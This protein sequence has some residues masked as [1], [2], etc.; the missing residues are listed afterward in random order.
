MDAFA[1]AAESA[2]KWPAGSLGA[3]YFESAEAGVDRLAAPEAAFALV[4]PSFLY[5]YGRKLSLEPVLEA[6]PLAGQGEA[7]ALVAGKGRVTSPASLAGWEITGA[8]GFSPSFV[9]EVLL[10]EWGPLPGDARIT[11][12][13]AI[14]GALRRA[15]TVEKLAVLL[16]RSQADAMPTLPFSTKLEVVRVSRTV[17]AALW[18]AVGKRVPQADSERLTQALLHLQDQ[19]SGK[20]ILTTLRIARFE[21]VNSAALADLRMSPSGTKP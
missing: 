8:P 5:E 11:F 12:S 16:D 2:A 6:K 14:L 17:P 21:K 1:S 3:I 15:A 18:C 20:E 19:Q 10:K 9:R 13:A 7:Y 4:P